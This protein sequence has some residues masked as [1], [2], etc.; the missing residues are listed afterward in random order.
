[1][2]RKHLRLT[3]IR[4]V[5]QTLFFLLFVLAIWATWTS[6]LK[7]YPVSRFLELDPL[8]ALS[9]A[10]ATGFVY[11][12]LGWSLLVVVLTLLFGR[13]FCNWICPFGTLHQFIGW[14]F[15]IRTSKE[16]LDQNRYR[17]SQFLKFSI[18]LVFLIMAAFGGLQIGLL[19]PI[20]VLYR[21]TATVLA[22]ASDMALSQVERLGLLVGTD[23]MVMNGLKFG[24]GAADRVFVGSFWIGVLFL[25]LVAANLWIPRFF[26]RFLCP[27]GALLGV[28]SRFSL[29]R[30]NRD[31]HRCT[32]CDLCLARC[33]GAA[34][35]HR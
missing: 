21:S 25:L 24:P 33:E 23:R 26:C 5:A 2:N 20:A 28:L 13:V 11:Q 4:L 6:R 17:P 14:L 16:R 29:F 3:N 12:F 32:D 10:L 18:L 8:V 9:T 31:V 15:N 35:P 34:D 30:I 1:M 22:P 27:T 19:D 7:G